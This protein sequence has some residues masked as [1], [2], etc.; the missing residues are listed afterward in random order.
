MLPFLRRCALRKTFDQY[1]HKYPTSRSVPVPT[2]RP[3]R[4]RTRA[5]EHCFSPQTEKPSPIFCSK[6]DHLRKRKISPRLGPKVSDPRSSQLAKPRS[7]Q[8]QP[9]LAAPSPHSRA[10]PETSSNHKIHPSPKPSASENNKSP[11]TVT[12]DE[13][14]YAY[15]PVTCPSG[16]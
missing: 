3:E 1:N 9:Q 2:V 12:T 8:P 4:V 14:K 13:A 15:S 7:P 6:P 16:G 10:N 5:A 11:A